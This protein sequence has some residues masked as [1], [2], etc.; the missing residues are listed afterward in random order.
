M[1]K[2]TRKYY[3]SVEG[4]TEKW[5]LDWL[6]KTINAISESKYNVKL[7]VKI[8]KDPLARVK[9]MTLLEQTEITHVFDRESEDSIHTK[10]FQETLDR[11]SDAEQLGKDINYKLGYS[12]FTFEL[13]IILHKADCNGAKTN[14]KQ[15]LSD[16]NKTYGEKFEDLNE[17]KRKNDFKRILKK[18]TIE[19]VISAVRR[20][21]T[22]MKR[23]EES[24]YRLQQYKG[25]SFYKENPSLSVWEIVREILSECGII[26]E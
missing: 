6:Q 3:F 5:Y 15:Y 25:F 7:D 18:I 19:D 23:N 14:R 21:E 16:L 22:I 2:E 24:G 17:Y 1:R 12:N 11:M 20:A 26:K 4:E 9:E 10:Q 13:W 8:Q